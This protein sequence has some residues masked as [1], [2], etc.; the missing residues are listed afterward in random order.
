LIDDHALELPATTEAWS[1]LH[2]D[3][4]RFA[5]IVHNPRRNLFDLPKPAGQ[6]HW[7]FFRLAEIGAPR[8]QFSRLSAGKTMRY[9]KARHD[10][11]NAL[12]EPLHIEEGDRS[13]GL[14]PGSHRMSADE[15]SS[16]SFAPRPIR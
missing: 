1:D 7:L 13:T 2:Q 9:D 12:S 4:R 8:A 3:V 16:R 5:A 14:A 10:L 6:E 15:L 11:P